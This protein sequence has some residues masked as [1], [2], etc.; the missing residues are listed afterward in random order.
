VPNFGHKLLPFNFGCS[1]KLYHTVFPFS[2]VSFLSLFPV[3]YFL[4]VYPF[5][6]RLFFNIKICYAKRQESLVQYDRFM[7]CWYFQILQRHLEYQKIDLG[8]C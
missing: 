8:N 4:T 5:L 1:E 3:I 2:S 7:N 6:S